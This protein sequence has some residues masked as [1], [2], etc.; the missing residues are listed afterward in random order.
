MKRRRT[1][2]QIR[3]PIQV[4]LTPDE[5]STLDR[6]ANLLDVSRA[7]ILR[8]GIEAIARDAYAEAADPLD[9]LVGRFDQPTAPCDLATRHDD[10]QADAIESEWADPADPSS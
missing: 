2:D 3:E 4:Y 9:E 10:Y 1:A 8:R 6:V 7:E 5:R